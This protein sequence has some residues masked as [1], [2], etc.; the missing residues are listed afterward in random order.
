MVIIANN[1][2]NNTNRQTIIISKG[3]GEL[4]SPHRS[5]LLLLKCTIRTSKSYFDIRHYYSCLNDV[6]TSYC[7]HSSRRWGS[8][9][10]AD[11]HVTVAIILTVMLTRVIIL[12]IMIH[13][14][15]IIIISIIILLLLL[16]LLIIIIILVM[17]IMSCPP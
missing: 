5:L 2:A 6:H 10:R 11:K 16:L 13:V 7:T 14:H 3:E 17:M 12:L 1:K 15:T 4:S 8:C 9:P